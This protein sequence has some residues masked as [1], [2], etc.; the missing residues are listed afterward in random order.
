[1]DSASEQPRYSFRERKKHQQRHA[2]LEAATALFA[3][4]GFDNVSVSDIAAEA[5]VAPRTVYNYFPD[6]A[7]LVLGPV[8]ELRERF[9]TAIRT[10]STRA[11]ADAIRPLVHDLIDRYTASPPED[12][13][14]QMPAQVAA[15]T[16]LRHRLL[17]DFDDTVDDV[18]DVLSTS[19]ESSTPLVHRLHAA[20]LV[21]VMQSSIDQ[22][23]AGCDQDDTLRVIRARLH[24]E[25]DAALHEVAACT[26]SHQQRRTSP[27]VRM[28]SESRT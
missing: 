10:R 24:D 3:V 6:R 23:G 2:I 26:L 16:A 17:R 28:P 13:R 25:V 5:E 8:A 19:G 27:P 9:L 7:D 4:H 11:P 14:G 1:M 12:T 20:A 15:S 18:A 22:I 21:A